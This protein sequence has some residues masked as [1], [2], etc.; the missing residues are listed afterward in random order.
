M[1]KSMTKIKQ[2]LKL[3]HKTAGEEFDPPPPPPC[4]FSKN[5]FSKER[6][7]PWFFVTFKA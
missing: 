6:F 1:K 3:K 2:K 5:V 7:K 4:G